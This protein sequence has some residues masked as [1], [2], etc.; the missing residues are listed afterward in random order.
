MPSEASRTLDKMAEYNER[1]LGV[2]VNLV[3]SYI[4]VIIQIVRIL[5]PFAGLGDAG[6]EAIKA[7]TEMVKAFNIKEA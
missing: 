5:L 3:K 7:I 4:Q 1:M 6:K 2:S